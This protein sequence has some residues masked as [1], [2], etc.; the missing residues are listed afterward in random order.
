MKEGVEL[1]LMLR[2]SSLKDMRITDP[3]VFRA[4][5]ERGGRVFLNP[6]L[7]TKF[8]VVDSREALVSSANITHSGLLPE[9]NLETA[10]YLKE[11]RKVRELEEGL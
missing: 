10:V 4:V 6:R 8:V 3:L 9:G 7:H 2:A 11:V 5:R 1:E